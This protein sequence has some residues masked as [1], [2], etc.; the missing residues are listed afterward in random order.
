MYNQANIYYNAGALKLAKAEKLN[1]K[2]D[3]E[4]KKIREDAKKYYNAADSKVQKLIIGKS[5]N[6]QLK[7][8]KEELTFDRKAAVKARKVLKKQ[9]ETKQI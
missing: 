1:R 8:I 4:N 9:S 5:E 6:L 2:S 7:W 3:R